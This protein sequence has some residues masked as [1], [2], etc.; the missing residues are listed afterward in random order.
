MHMR[1]CVFWDVKTVSSAGMGPYPFWSCTL[2]SSWRFLVDTK[3]FITS[4]WRL[5]I[6]SKLH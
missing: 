4:A 2:A 3:K 6:P 1:I 5:C